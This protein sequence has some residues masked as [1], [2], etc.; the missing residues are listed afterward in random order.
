[1]PKHKKRKPQN[2]SKILVWLGG[3]VLAGLAG[4]VLLR[5]FIPTAYYELKDAAREISFK[6]RGVGIGQAAPGFQS[7]TQNGEEVELSRLRGQTVILAFSTT[8][9][10]DCRAQIPL[11]TQFHGSAPDLVVLDVDTGESLSTVQSYV[12]GLQLVYPVLM[13]SNGEI[14]R[15]YQVTAYPTL[16][17]IDPTGN[18]RA[19][20]IGEAAPDEMDE[21]LA[22][23]RHSD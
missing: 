2:R 5:L 10:P 21:I 13:D 15:A 14:A 4:I 8:W 22:K 23:I 12:K 20:I 18:I 16:F 6:M 7:E 19:R 17:V 3:A 9:C 11:L 1:M